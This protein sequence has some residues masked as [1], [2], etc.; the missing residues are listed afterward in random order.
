MLKRGLSVFL[1]AVFM[2]LCFFS[3]PVFAAE[4][5][6][7]ISDY[8]IEDLQL[9]TTAEKKKLMEDFIETYNP[10]GI[11]DL[12]EQK[13]S[14]SGRFGVQPLWKSDSDSSEEGQQMATHQMVTLQ[15]MLMF[16]L[17]YGFYDVDVSLQLVIALYVAAASGLPDLD[18]TD[19][20]FAEHFYDPRTGCGLNLLLGSARDKVE[21]HYKY[22][23]NVLIVNPYMSV[24][25]EPA[26]YIWEQLGRALHF[27]QDV[28]EPHHASTAAGGVSTHTQFENH[29]ENN[30]ESL[31][32]QRKTMPRSS[33]AIAKGKTTGE[34]THNAALTGRNRYKDVWNLSDK[35]K[36]DS[37]A[38]A[39]LDDAICY[40]ARVIYK[41]FA[42]C[43]VIA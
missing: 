34:L 31:L 30:I 27:I 33:Y 10:Y 35:S 9:M 22:A 2:I 1:A 19:G 8:T 16:M 36:W 11:R 28:C 37:T 17:D 26:Y 40:S 43:G 14:V 38:T 13:S 3:V 12:M 25:S 23:Y 4:P 5:A 7:D 21:S 39:C 42:D 20:V 32:P 18:E 6:F 15:A 41:L 29:V 24:T